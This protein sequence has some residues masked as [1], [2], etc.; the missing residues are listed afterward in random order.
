MVLVL[1]RLASRTEALP[2]GGWTVF[3]MLH[4][5]FTFFRVVLIVLNGCG[6]FA[7]RQVKTNI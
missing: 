1:C 4:C 7:R 3:A 2:C 6:F 5:I